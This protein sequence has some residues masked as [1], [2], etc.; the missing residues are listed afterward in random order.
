MVKRKRDYRAEYRRRI[1]GARAKGLSKAQ[2]RGHRKAGEKAS[3]RTARERSVEDHKIQIALR[4]LRRTKSVSTAAKE[5]HLSPEKLRQIATEKGILEKRGRRWVVKS[6]I[7]R[8]VLVYS[9][10]QRSIITIGT[11]KM[12]SL[13]GQYMSAVGRFL[14]TGDQALLRPFANKAVVD[15]AGNKHPLETRP[16]ALYRLSFSGGQSFEQI[17]R[18]VV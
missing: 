11:M 9:G 4:T 6:D 14:E 2:A 13:A 16:N 5:A 8:R 12:A 1:A 7:A 10:G 3:R 18:I 17:Y 15:D